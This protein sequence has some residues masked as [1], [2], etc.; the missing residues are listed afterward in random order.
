LEAAKQSGRRRLVEIAT[1]VALAD[2]LNATDGTML[3]FSER[4][5]VTIKEAIADAQDRSEVVALIGPEG[6]WEEGELALMEDSGCLMI[7]LGPRTLRTE[8]A[9]IAAIT[10]LQHALGD[11]SRSDLEL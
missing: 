11:L 6:G 9:A 4:G 1:P 2:F 3:V 8:T 7:T 5:G 10:L